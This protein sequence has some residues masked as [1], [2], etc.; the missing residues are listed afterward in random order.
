M[1]PSVASSPCL[2]D[3]ELSELVAGKITDEERRRAETHLASCESCSELVAAVEQTAPAPGPPD[4]EPVPTPAPEVAGRY[5]IAKLVGTGATGAVYRAWDPSLSRFVALKLLRARV[6]GDVTDDLLLAEAHAL[7][8]LSHP[9]VVTIHDVGTRD[10]QVFLA[11][12]LARTSLRSWLREAPRSPREVLPLLR[13]AGEGLAAAHATGLVHR[14]VKPDNILLAHDGRALVTDFGLARA[15]RTSAGVPSDAPLDEAT[16]TS[17]GLLIGTPAY[18][19]PEQLRGEVADERSDQFG[20]CVT[21]FEALT[22][23]RPFPAKTIPELQVAVEKEQLDRSA[24]KRLP[25]WL[26]KILL[27]GLRADPDERWPSLRHLLDA[28]AAGPPMSRTGVRLGALAGV[29]A[30]L[31]VASLSWGLVETARQRERAERRFA[32]V[33]RLANA[34]LFEFDDAIQDLPGAT[35]ARRLVIQRAQEY[36]DSLAAEA[37][38]DLALQ[39]E[40]ATAYVRLYE[41]QGGGNTNMGDTAG[42]LV[43]LA[44]ATAIREQIAATTGKD[45]DLAALAGVLMESSYLRSTQPE[46]LRDIERTIEL[47]EA[48]AARAPGDAR[49]QRG[50][51]NAY[52]SLGE[53]LKARGQ[54]RDALPHL[55]RAVATYERL[56][57]A[58]PTSEVDKR[59]AALGAKYLGSALQK[60]DDF[61]GAAEQYRRAIA[62]DGMRVAAAPFDT[63]AKLDLSYSIASLANVQNTAGDHA[64]AL[65]AYR[66]ALALRQ[67]IASADPKNATARAAVARAHHTVGR[68]LGDMGDGLAHIAELTRAADIYDAL[69]AADPA[70]TQ[71]VARVAEVHLDLAEA[72]LAL[73]LHPRT[74]PADAASHLGAGRSWSQRALAEMTGIRDKGASSRELEVLVRA[75]ATV[76]VIDTLRATRPDLLTRSAG[77]TLEAGR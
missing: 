13:Q 16:V 73:V 44:K 59:N 23:K 71:L 42:A 52:L 32:D 64:G 70:D 3:T 45:D 57:A 33:R 40:L 51:A 2:S 10:G 67:A 35:G 9:N 18:M 62:L 1:D 25:V 74:A 39:R 72:H 21:L 77:P 15:R 30:V 48:L 7:A 37:A 20:Y 75:A 11:M 53:L 69:I 56:H 12:E 41:I 5:N 22:G 61:P 27:R 68:V 19:A 24:V 17:T 55:R 8:R 63:Q 54:Y 50:L 46:G 49:R 26:R 47:R 31:L 65:A 6:E 29:A 4:D 66:Q 38:D 76:A 60:T 43:S 14:D 28:L 34:F 58:D 36:L